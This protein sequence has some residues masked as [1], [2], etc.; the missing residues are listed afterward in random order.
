MSSDVG[1]RVA[2]KDVSL[3]SEDDKKAKKRLDIVS[4]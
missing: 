4:V 3:P 1:D 2:L